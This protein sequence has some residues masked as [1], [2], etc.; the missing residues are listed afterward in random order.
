[1]QDLKK[2]KSAL[3][4]LGAYL[5]QPDLA[6]EGAIHKAFLY[7]AWFE[8]SHTKQAIQ[9]I[10]QNYLSAEKIEQWLANYKITEPSTPKKIGIIAAGNLPLVCFHDILCVLITGNIAVI[11]LSDKDKYLMPF[12]L[13]KLVEIEPDFKDY[14]E[15][16]ER[17]VKPDA[18]I[19]TGSDNSSRYFEFYFGKYPNIIRKN[20]HSIAILDGSENDME[21]NE[22][23]NDVFNY[24]GMGCRNVS[25]LHIPE[26]F[27][28][29]KLK[30]AWSNFEPIMNHNKYRNNLD[31]QRTIYLMSIIPMVDIDFV[32]IVDNDR[33]GSPIS[34]LHIRKYKLTAEIDDFI[35]INKNEIQ[36]IVGKNNIPF[37]KSQSPELWDYAD[38]EDTIAF[39]LKL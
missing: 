19:A 30:T 15:I 29:L 39:L 9:S 14:F 35:T 18:I 7:N 26:D 1:M 20:R 23:G 21:L 4:K 6:L 32:N 22:L 33:M 28:I 25:Q 34:C 12:I 31:Y 24:F 11:K 37:G 13:E 36:C 8:P 3:I 2:R 38:N 17:I 16:V 10:C 27:D 5:N